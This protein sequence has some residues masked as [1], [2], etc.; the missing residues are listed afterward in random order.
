VILG[1]SNETIQFMF[2]SHSSTIELLKK[3]KLLYLVKTQVAFAPHLKK[4]KLDFLRQKKKKG[5]L[6][7]I[8]V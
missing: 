1:V 5:K 4:G 8:Y 3:K 2:K 7:G 6:A